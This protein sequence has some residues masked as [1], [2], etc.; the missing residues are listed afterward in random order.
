MDAPNRLRPVTPGVNPR[1]KVSEICF[2]VLL[3]VAHRYPVDSRTCLPLLT[4]ERPF[5]RFD[6][7]VMQQGGKPGLD[8]RAGRRVHPCEIGWQG[9]P[10]LCPDLA[11]LA[12]V[13]SGLV[14]SL[15]AP[16]FL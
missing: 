4:S 2:Q 7:Y 16:R 13:P 12:Q 15:G 5:Q 9:N 3:V 1:T 8:G 14:P 11:P 10:A 6:V